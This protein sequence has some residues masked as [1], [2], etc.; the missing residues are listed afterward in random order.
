MGNQITLRDRLKGQ[1]MLVALYIVSK[2]ATSFLLLDI[3]AK[4]NWRE[5]LEK[6]ICMIGI[7]FI[8]M[9]FFISINKFNRRK[10]SA[11]F[12]GGECI[13]FSLTILYM[14]LKRYYILYEK[15]SL[16][17]ICVYAV[18]GIVLFLCCR[19][20]SEEQL[21]KKDKKE[22]RKGLSYAVIASV[23]GIGRIL[24]TDQIYMKNIIV[25]LMICCGWL[26]FGWFMFKGAKAYINDSEP[27]TTN[28]T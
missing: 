13:I 3:D 17:I 10:F 11:Y 21:D 26:A 1:T 15:L 2:M 5:E 28:E 25:S 24:T 27:E 9:V 8:V 16:G 20:P 18:I 7:I 14:I 12:A 6:F 19:V 22:S 4:V 23:I